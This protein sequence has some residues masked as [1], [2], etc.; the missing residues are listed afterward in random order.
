MDSSNVSKN[1]NSVRSSLDNLEDETIARFYEPIIISD[2]ITDER[3]EVSIFEGMLSIAQNLMSFYYQYYGKDERPDGSQP[4]QDFVADNALNDVLI[5]LEKIYDVILDDIDL[6]L[7]KIDNALLS[8]MVIIFTLAVISYTI[9][10]FTEIRF[11]KYKNGFIEVF[12]RVS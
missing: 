1:I 3:R 10:L 7:K 12:M 11:V 5:M 8:V 6:K 9:V 2:K 4:Q